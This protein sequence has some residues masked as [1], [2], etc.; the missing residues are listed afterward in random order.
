MVLG[1]S[2]ILGQMKDAVRTQRGR[3]IRGNTEQVVSELI[4]GGQGRSFNDGHWRQYCLH[5]GGIDATG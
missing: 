1:E 4:C 3:H 5:G 2:R